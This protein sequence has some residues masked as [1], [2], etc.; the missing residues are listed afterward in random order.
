V[1]RVDAN[2]VVLV[3][4]VRRHVAFLSLHATTYQ[5]SRRPYFGDRKP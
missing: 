5:A 2:L 4:E 1:L 3:E